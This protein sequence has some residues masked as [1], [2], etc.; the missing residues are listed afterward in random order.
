[1]HQPRVTLG[2]IAKKT[3][4]SRSGVSRALR[5]DPSIPRDTCLRIQ[6]IARSLGYVPDPEVSALMHKLKRDRHR[7]YVETIVYLND[8]PNPVR[9]SGVPYVERLFVGAS[10]RAASL[11][12]RLEEFWLRS[13]GMS[14]KRAESILLNRGI[15]GVLVGPFHHAGLSVDFPWARFAAVA[16]TYGQQ[17]PRLH[18]V[19]PANFQNLRLALRESAARGC[20]RP[21]LCLARGVN[22]RLQDIMQAVLLLH[23][24]EN[25]DTPPLPLFEPENDTEI[26]PVELRRW[27]E[28]NKPDLVLAPAIEVR[29][30]LKA[31]GLRIPQDIGFVHLDGRPL[32]TGTDSVCQIDQRPDLVGAAAV[33]FLTGMLLR[34]ETGVPNFAHTLLVSGTWHAG[35]SLPT[36][37]RKKPSL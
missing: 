10:E 26:E 19:L 13:P 12:Y 7:R 22:H 25:L 11:G 2:T 5:N 28:T 33:E 35:K 16:M 27:L 14:G 23:C 8:L 15:R 31:A 1:M 20:Q 9:K 6:K 32:S 24:Q 29:A 21:G 30:A 4:L 18:S 34:A 36:V 17:S 37:T 3:K